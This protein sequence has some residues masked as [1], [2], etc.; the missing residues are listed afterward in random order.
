MSE[1]RRRAE[2]VLWLFIG[3]SLCVGLI[4][5]VGIGF[6]GGVED[7]FTDNP[8]GTLFAAS[9]VLPLVYWIYLR[10]KHR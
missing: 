4:T 2:G 5:L 8:V 6:A 9:P 1:R 3:W 7:A 10:G